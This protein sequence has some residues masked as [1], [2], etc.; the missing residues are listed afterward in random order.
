MSNSADKASDV[1]RNA[2]HPLN[3]AGEDFDVLMDWIGDAR[4]VLLGEASHGTHEFY[5]ARARITQQLIEEKGF[6]AVVAEADWPDAWRVNRYA[7]G[8]NDDD[9][10]DAALAGFRRFPQ[11]MWRNEDVLE[12]VEWLRLHNAAI[13][14]RLPKVGFHGMDLY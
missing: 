8:F 3:G 7:R 13:P 9:S 6:T 12:F 4:F 1:V 10:A 2:A 5:Q 11:W 14:P